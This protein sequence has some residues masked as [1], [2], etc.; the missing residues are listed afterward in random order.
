MKIRSKKTH[1]LLLGENGQLGLFLKSYLSYFFQIKGLNKQNCDLRDYDNLKSVIEQFKPD[2]L[3][4]AAAFTNVE[5]AEINKSLAYDINGKSLDIISNVCKSLNIF[6]IHISTDYVFDGRKKTFYS[7]KDIPK[8]INYYGKT[9]LDGEEFIIN[10]MNKFLILRTSWVYSGFK[11]NF[12]LNIV[13]KAQTEK[14]IK[15]VCD[16]FG[17]PTSTFLLAQ[18]IYKTIEKYVSDEK[19]KYP[20]GLYNV[21]SSGKISWYE[22]AKFITVY[23]SKILHF[24]NSR[25]VIIKP[26]MSDELDQLAKRPKNSKLDNSLFEKTFD[27]KLPSWDTDLNFILR[28]FIY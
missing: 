1:I 3:I 20:F 28:N 25:Q 15:V 14:E 26:I 17:S 6:L 22:Y 7:E 9:K 8:P 21:T 23:L 27:I 4:N 18:S 11:N 12:F 24:N 10:N 13:R 5:K 2:I 19:S 16:Q